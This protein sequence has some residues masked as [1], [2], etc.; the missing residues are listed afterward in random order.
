MSDDSYESCHYRTLGVSR[1]ATREEIKA[2]FRKLS[3][4]THP[5]VAGHCA[6]ADR[7]KRIANAARVLTKERRA[8]D[9]SSSTTAFG[10]TSF[11][12]HRPPP[13]RYYQGDKAARQASSSGTNGFTHFLVAIFRPR[14]LILGPMFAFGVVSAIQYGL[15]IENEKLKHVD[16]SRDLVQAWK[17]PVTRRYETAAPW[18][19]LYQQLQPTLE[20]VPRHQVHSRHR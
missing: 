3:K 16:G 7:F 19:P 15:G 14:N 8:Y 2:A 9:R 18:D 1:G 17:N 10:A 13:P 20:L 12:H 11:H 6:D 5:D 4:E